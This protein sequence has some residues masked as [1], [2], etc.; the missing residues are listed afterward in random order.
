MQLLSPAAARVAPDGVKLIAYECM[1]DL[2]H[3][4]PDHNAEGTEQPPSVCKLPGVFKNPL[5]W[6]VSTAKVVGKPVALLNASLLGG[7]FAQNT[8]LETLR[9]MNWRVEAAS[10]VKPFVR[11]KIV[12]EVDDEEML[13]VLRARCNLLVISPRVTTC[14]TKQQSLNSAARQ[15]YQLRSS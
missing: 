14:Q 13:A 1:G 15:P 11:R 3:C 7:E 8:I 10:R 12:G 6:L 2:P 5:D 9:T 4:N